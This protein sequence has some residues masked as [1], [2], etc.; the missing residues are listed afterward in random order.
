MDAQV[1]IQAICDEVAAFSQPYDVWLTPTVGSPALPL[2]MFKG[3]PEEPNRA[4]TTSM[5]FLPFTMLQNMT[6]QPAMSIP[7][8]WTDDG[9]PIGL[10]FVGPYGDEGLLFRLAAQLEEARPWA[11]RV[12][13]TNALATP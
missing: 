6:G 12:P 8:V 10:Q 11:D 9:L 5:K 3:T 13:P 7:L 2:G 4:M 1:T